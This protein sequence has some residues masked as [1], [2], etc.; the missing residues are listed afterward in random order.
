M[1]TLVTFSFLKNKDSQPSFDAE[2]DS[3]RL[4][5]E[6]GPLPVL[7]PELPLSLDSEALP[8]ADF[9]DESTSSNFTEKVMLLLREGNESNVASPPQADLPQHTRRSERNKKPFPGGMIMLGFYL[10]LPDRPRKGPP[11]VLP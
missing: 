2:S 9:G 10:F 6:P 8:S 11:L 5:Y 4:D 1:W 7:T 3:P